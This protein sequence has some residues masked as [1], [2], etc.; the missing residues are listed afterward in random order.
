[1]VCFDHKEFYQQD[2]DHGK[3]LYIFD[4]LILAVFYLYSDNLYKPNVKKKFKELN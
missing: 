2:N 4:K 1:M 3:N